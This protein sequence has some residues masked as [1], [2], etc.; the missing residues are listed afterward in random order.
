MVLFM[1]S[2]DWRLKDAKLHR[3]QG[4]VEVVTAG[5][6]SFNRPLFEEAGMP[7]CEIP[8]DQDDE[9]VRSI[10][11]NFIETHLLSR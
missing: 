9:E 6:P 7:L 2:P 10:L 5:I 1:E 4:V 8:R 3:C 11:S